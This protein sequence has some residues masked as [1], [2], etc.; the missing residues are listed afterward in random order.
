[1]TTKNLLILAHWSWKC[2]ATIAWEKIRNIGKK[3]KL[4]E[5]ENMDHY[6][7]SSHQQ[8]KHLKQD[9]QTL[10]K[11]N[12]S[13][14]QKDQIV[15]LDDISIELDLVQSENSLNE[16]YILSNDRTRTRHSSLESSH[17]EASNG[18]KIKSLSSIDREIA[19]V[20]RIQ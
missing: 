4:N 7:K 2:N 13:D 10:K 20:R 15:V 3:E 1:M 9:K 11:N 18:G 19:H 6:F 5:S 8:V 17:R 16:N 14:L 12:Y